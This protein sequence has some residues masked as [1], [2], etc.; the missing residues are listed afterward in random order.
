M[1][2]LN[3]TGSI[4]PVGSATGRPPSRSHVD[5]RTGNNGQNNVVSY[6]QS[7]LTGLT[8]DVKSFIN[9]TPRAGSVYGRR[10]GT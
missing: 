1:I 4:N 7:G 8:F 2:W 9:D 3:H 6:V 5:S 10:R